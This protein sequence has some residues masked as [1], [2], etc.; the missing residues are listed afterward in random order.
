[1]CERRPEVK[2]RQNKTKI[3]VRKQ[4]ADNEMIMRQMS[5]NTKLLPQ[6]WASH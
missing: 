5:F 3:Q 6:V 2:K 1:M 4:W